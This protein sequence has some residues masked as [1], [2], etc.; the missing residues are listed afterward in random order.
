MVG[1]AY[2]LIPEL[3]GR[4]L[5]EVDQLFESKAPLRKFGGVR[6]MTAEELYQGDLAPRGR[7]IGGGKLHDNGS[8]AS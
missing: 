6:T 5:E 8:D 4:T 7:G 2:F 3:K 1:L